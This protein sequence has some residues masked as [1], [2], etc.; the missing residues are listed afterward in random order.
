MR[1][2]VAS[3]RLRSSPSSVHYKVHSATGGGRLLKG[4]ARGGEIAVRETTFGSA[5]RVGAVRCSAEPHSGGQKWSPAQS[6][7][8]FSRALP[9]SVDAT[10]ATRFNSSG[11]R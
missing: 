10:T 4:N 1:R 8:Y 11:R 2:S 7:Q 3:E 5:M 9:L 6:G